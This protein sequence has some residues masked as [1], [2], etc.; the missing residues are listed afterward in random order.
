MDRLTRSQNGGYVV[1]Q[2]KVT[3]DPG[4]YSGEAINRLGKFEDFLE[5]LMTSQN[6]IPG[7][8]QKLRDEGKEKSY[9]YK[10]LMGK[11][12]SDSYILNLLKS[13]GIE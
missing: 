3:P 4:G 13:Y 10:E 6:E 8:L 9:R 12:L 2:T 1:D 5:H 7:Q 11:K